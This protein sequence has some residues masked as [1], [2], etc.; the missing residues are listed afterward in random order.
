M[1]KRDQ[2]TILY[3]FG[4][5]VLSAAL[6]PIFIIPA[7]AESDPEPVSPA[8]N[9]LAEENSMAKAAI[10]GNEISF[11]ADDF[12]RATNLSSI[13]SI[14]VTEI[15][16]ITDGEL[17]LGNKVLTGKT[18]IR[19][20][21][22]DLLSYTPSKAN[23]NRSSFEFRVN[24]SPVDIKCDLFFLDKYNASPTLDVASDASL[25]VSSHS[26]I[27]LYGTLPFHD[28]E[29]DKTV[30]DIV[31]YPKKGLLIMTDRENGEY[32]YIP[33]KN[34]AGKD[35]FRYVV[36]DIYGNYSASATVSLTINKQR[37]SVTYADMIGRAGYNDAI[38]VTENGIMSGSQIGNELFFRPSG[39]VT[40]EEFLV[41]A[42]N[43]LGMREVSDVDKTVF[44][45]DA[46]ISDS[47]KGHVKVAY[48]LGYIKGERNKNGEL[49]FYPDRAITR[50]E[51]A[52]IVASMID[53]A[54]PTVKPVFNDE[55]D[56]PSYAAASIYSLNY[57][58]IM[59]AFDGSF[60]PLD[61][62]SRI[63]AAKIMAAL[64]KY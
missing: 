24:S 47:M 60:S 35:E 39:T 42:M 22:L 61:D 4:A 7:L 5:L 28:P 41:M 29:G 45:D 19:T 57:M 58:G 26:N 54:T 62:L 46:D 3:S 55:R 1:K 59:T 14:T 10:I 12:S 33:K 18:T 27:T 32:M 21:N 6:L 15:P 34:F 30:V 37:T 63:E 8:L 20:S 52:C 51:A 38:T 44:S 23:I 31:S 13:D 16:P 48:E 64:L 50:A 53:A 11:S 9:I 36:R 56:I 40:R 2:K 25:Q 43:S 49:C 17:R